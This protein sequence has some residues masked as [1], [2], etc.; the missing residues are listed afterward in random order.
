MTRRKRNEEIIT[1]SC[2]QITGNIKQ[3]KITSSRLLPKFF[4]RVCYPTGVISITFVREYH[5]I[6]QVKNWNDAQAYCRAT[7]D[8]LATMETASDITKLQSMSSFRAWVGLYTE[9]SGWH[10]SLNNESLGSVTQWNPNALLNGNQMCTVLT[11]Y[12]G[13]WDTLCTYYLP[14]TCFDGENQHIVHFA[15]ILIG[16]QECIS[17]VQV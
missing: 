2:Y 9:R 12:S 16:V 14:F 6:Q 17:S 10:W 13:W 3:W 4:L 7:Y 1:G 8:D 15:I 5:L 11:Y